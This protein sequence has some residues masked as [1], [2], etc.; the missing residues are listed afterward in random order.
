MALVST[1]QHPVK[2]RRDS[3]AKASVSLGSTDQSLVYYH[4]I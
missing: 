2:L 4:F 1:H 3:G